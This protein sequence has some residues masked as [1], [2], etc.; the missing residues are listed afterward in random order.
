[1]CAICE[2]HPSWAPYIHVTSTKQTTLGSFF[3]APKTGAAPPPRPTQQPVKK[4]SSQNLPPPSSS[5]ASTTLRTPSSLA[6][7]SPANRENGRP[8]AKRAGNPLKQAIELR[9]G[10][11]DDL[12]PPPDEVSHTTKTNGAEH[13]EEEKE[14]ESMDIDNDGDGSPMIMVCPSNHVRKAVTVVCGEYRR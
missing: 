11:G 10:S 8:V 12:S 14:E 4:S 2:R 3:G 13:V 7:S 5:P 1:M 9:S 6:G